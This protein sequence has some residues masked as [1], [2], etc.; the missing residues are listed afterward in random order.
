MPD[1]IPLNQAAR[2]RRGAPPPSDESPDGPSLENPPVTALGHLD[3]EFYFLDAAGQLRALKASQLSRRGDVVALFGEQ[4]LNWLERLF[5]RKIIRK[6]TTP[7][8]EE[9]TETIAGFAVNA[10][11]DWLMGQA[12]KAGLFGEHLKFKK[13]GIWPGGNETPILHCGDAVFMDGQVFPAG[14]RVGNMVFAA[15]GAKARPGPPADKSVA[16][17]IVADMRMLWNYSRVGAEIVL[18]GLV[19][20]GYLGAAVPWRSNG[21]LIGESGSGKTMLLSLLRACSPMHHYTSDTSKAGIEQAVNGNA[22]QIIVEEAADREDQRGAKALMDIVLSATGG[23]G[24][25]GHRGSAGGLVRT[26][27]VVGSIIMASVAPPAMKPQHEARFTMVETRSPEDGADNTDAHKAAIARAAVVAPSLWGRAV[28]GLVR[29]SKALEVF[30][31][32]LGD[33]GC[34]PR[35]RDQ[36]GAILAGW[37]IMTHDGVP[38]ARDGRVGVAA[39]AEYVRSSVEVAQ[40]NAKRRMLDHLLSSSVSMDRSS[41][42]DTIGRLIE[43]AFMPDIYT[44]EKPRRVLERIGIRC[45]SHDEMRDAQNREIPRKGDGDGLW[46]ANRARGLQEIFHGSDFDGDR[47]QYQVK[48]LETARKSDG[49]VRIGGNSTRAIWVSRWEIVGDDNGPVTQ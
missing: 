19:A 42:Q 27:D 48:R 31:A 47:W 46:F 23:E 34:A 26:I 16:Q 1:P 30:R 14:L 2:R 17:D 36:A 4:N 32:A 33:A 37:W 44:S 8:G 9:F 12:Q 49:A 28:A 21:F 3:G 15:S 5:P 6:I 40:D 24:T 13:P 39:M 18:M 38:D 10:V 25:K 20:V 45:V 35:E 22:M 29:F 41:E 7:Q 43:L 11:S